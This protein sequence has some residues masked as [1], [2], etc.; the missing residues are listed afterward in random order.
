ML[1]YLHNVSSLYKLRDLGEQN[2][3]S[4]FRLVVAKISH[5]EQQSACKQNDNNLPYQ[6]KLK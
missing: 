1:D 6:R 4:S 3:R 5:I 2:S